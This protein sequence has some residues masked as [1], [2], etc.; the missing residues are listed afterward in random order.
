MS[1]AAQLTGCCHC[2]DEVLPHSV[3]RRR[4]AAGALIGMACRA[5][6]GVPSDCDESAIQRVVRIQVRFDACMTIDTLSTAIPPTTNMTQARSSSSSSS[7]PLETQKMLTGVDEA[8]CLNGAELQEDTVCK[9]GL[10]FVFCQF[11]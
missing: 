7:P 10:L 8:T 2:E 6:N 3:V 4:R 5:N 9:S 11:S 1:T